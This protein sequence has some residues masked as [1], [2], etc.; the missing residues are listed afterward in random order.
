MKP[1]NRRKYFRVTADYVAQLFSNGLAFNEFV[2]LPRALGLPVAAFVCGC[3]FEPCENSFQ[4]VVQDDS[5]D[6]V[7]DGIRI[8]R[9]EVVFESVRLPRK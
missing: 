3:Y 1:S 5:F 7:P 4:I 8:P 2:V 6:E 9:L